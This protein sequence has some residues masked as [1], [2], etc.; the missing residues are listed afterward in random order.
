MELR[1]YPYLLALNSYSACGDY[2]RGNRNNK[3]SLEIPLVPRSSAHVTSHV[4]TSQDLLNLIITNST[5]LHSVE[6][7]RNFKAIAGG[8]DKT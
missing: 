4:E 8:L 7:Y 6:S 5:I 3:A 2:Q 1:R